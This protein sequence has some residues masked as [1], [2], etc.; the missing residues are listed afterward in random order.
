MFDNAYDFQWLFLLDKKELDNELHLYDY[1]IDNYF[2][3]R[4]KFYTSVIP[5]YG[6]VYALETNNQKMLEK[7]IEKLKRI[8]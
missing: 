8:I 5:Y 4:I 2:Y 7:E 1:N 6:V 3:K